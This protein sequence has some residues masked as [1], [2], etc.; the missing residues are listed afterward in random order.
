MKKILKFLPIAFIAIALTSCNNDDDDSARVSVDAYYKVVNTGMT[1]DGV[2][3][4]TLAFDATSTGTIDSASVSYGAGAA[5]VVLS[6]QDA[7][8][9]SHFYGE[10]NAAT[11][12]GNEGLIVYDF[13]ITEGS[14][15][16]ILT[17]QINTAELVAPA[18]IDVASISANADTL[19]FAWTV[20]AD[21]GQDYFTVEVTKDGSVVYQDESNINVDKGETSIVITPADAAWKGGDKIESGLYNITLSTVKKSGMTTADTGKFNCIGID[22]VEKTLSIATE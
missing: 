4:Y 9:G 21:N 17:D 19:Q 1:S 3:D 5:T 18:L 15:G 10:T 8:N 2:L 22:E 12:T 14:G 6:K 13:T 20:V 16:Q 7:T 11:P